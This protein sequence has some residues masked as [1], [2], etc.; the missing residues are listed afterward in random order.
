VSELVDSD[1][2]DCRF[3]GEAALCFYVGGPPVF[4]PSGSVSGTRET[5]LNRGER[6][7]G[8]R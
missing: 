6:A 8:P 4:V 3:H 5:L 7:Q 1:S 2:L